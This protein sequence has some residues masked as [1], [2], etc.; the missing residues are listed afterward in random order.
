ML[1]T[2]EI[3]LIGGGGGTHPHFGTGRYVPQQGKKWGG[4]SGTSWSMKMGVSGTNI[5][6]SRTDFVGI[7]GASR[8]RYSELS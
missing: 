6:H 8:T 4:G 2:T 7:R 5:A 3:N 1:H